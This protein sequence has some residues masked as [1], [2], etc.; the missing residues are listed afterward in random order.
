M[1]E[2]QS[3]AEQRSAEVEAGS[4]P[5][6]TEDGFYQALSSRRRRRL[7]SVLLGRDERTVEELATVLTGWETTETGGMA[8]PEDRDTVMT[9]LLQ[10][11]L[12]L[13]EEAGLIVYDRDQGTDRAE[14][15]DAA[16][17]DLITRSIR[18]ESQSTG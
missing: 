3:N 12:P 15:L 11:H 7:L 2:D 18:A 10:V 6:L 13:L 9:S 4:D 8:T 14:S 1:N 17:A 16:V 5:L